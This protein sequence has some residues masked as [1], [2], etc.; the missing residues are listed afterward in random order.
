MK[1]YDYGYKFV[2]KYNNSPHNLIIKHVVKRAR[3][4]SN[5]GQIFYN[6]NFTPVC[7][8]AN[9]LHIF[10]EKPL[11]EKLGKEILTLFNVCLGL[12]LRLKVV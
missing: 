5:T 1:C 6:V 11:P 12:T 2:K 10:K 4:K 7:Y 8:H 9:N 3:G